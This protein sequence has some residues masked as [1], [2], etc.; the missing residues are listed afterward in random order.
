M[1]EMF[2]VFIMMKAGNWGLLGNRGMVYSYDEHLLVV[3][4]YKAWHLLWDGKGY[5]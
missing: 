4:G 2:I 5:W 3:Q 1:G